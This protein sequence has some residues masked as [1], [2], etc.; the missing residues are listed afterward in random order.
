MASGT[1][2]KE[3]LHGMQE[4]GGSIPPGSTISR[5]DFDPV[6]QNSREMIFA[7]LRIASLT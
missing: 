1:R 5:P 6:D 3:R 4:V 2:D 7:R